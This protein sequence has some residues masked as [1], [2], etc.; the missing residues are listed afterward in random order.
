MNAIIKW[1]NVETFEKV[2]RAAEDRSESKI[3]VFNL[4]VE[5][6]KLLNATFFITFSKL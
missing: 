1:T 4:L 2:K 6:D 3:I 5:N